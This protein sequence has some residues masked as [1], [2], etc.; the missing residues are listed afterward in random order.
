MAPQSDTSN[1]PGISELERLSLLHGIKLG[2]GTEQGQAERALRELLTSCG[3]A[4]DSQSAVQSELEQSEARLLQ[5]VYVVDQ[6]DHGAI[7]VRLLRGVD[8]FRF[9][10]IN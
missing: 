10:I 5:P 9:I 1:A 3:I 8:H 2:A 6:G 4:A 7:S